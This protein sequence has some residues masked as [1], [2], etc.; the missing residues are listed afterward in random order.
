MLLFI[1][2]TYTQ[3]TLDTNS[4]IYNM[5]IRLHIQLISQLYQELLQKLYTKLYN[6]INS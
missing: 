2:P 3:I 1:I 6:Q 4:E 5:Y